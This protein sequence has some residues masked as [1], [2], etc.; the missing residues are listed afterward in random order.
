VVLAGKG[1]ENYQ[2]VGAEKRHFDDVEEAT[3]AIRSNSRLN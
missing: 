2:I 1:H 3:A